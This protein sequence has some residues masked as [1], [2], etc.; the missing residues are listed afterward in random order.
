[1]SLHIALCR[2]T[3]SLIDTVYLQVSKY[4]HVRYS[5]E[6]QLHCAH[7]YTIA[8]CAHFNAVWHASWTA[9]GWPHM[10]VYCRT[11]DKLSQRGLTS[12][13][14]KLYWSYSSSRRVSIASIALNLYWCDYVHLSF[15]IKWKFVTFGRYV[16]VI[17]ILWKT[18]KMSCF[19]RKY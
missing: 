16:T 2:Y 5:D 9:V 17:F 7:T 1:M 14:V 8:G 3:L 4:Q 6:R 13:D 15:N 12:L 10:Y 11:A 18:D 19:L